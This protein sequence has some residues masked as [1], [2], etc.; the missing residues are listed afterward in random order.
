MLRFVLLLAA[1]VGL[2]VAGFVFWMR[3]ADGAL[4][5]SQEEIEAAVE[6]LL[7]RTKALGADSA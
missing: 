6:N 5:L 1:V 2:A 4:G 3:P 7:E